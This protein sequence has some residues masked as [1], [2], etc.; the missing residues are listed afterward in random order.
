MLMGV[1]YVPMR[2]LVAMDVGVLMGVDVFVFMFTFHNN[3]SSLFHVGK[4]KSSFP[5]IR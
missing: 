2:M 1:L 4:L 3:G 5:P